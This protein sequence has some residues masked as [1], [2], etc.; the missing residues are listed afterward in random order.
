MCRNMHMYHEYVFQVHYIQ[1]YM[2]PHMQH[3]TFLLEPDG[4]VSLGGKVCMLLVCAYVDFSL[5]V[6]CG[7]NWNYLLMLLAAESQHSKGSD[8]DHWA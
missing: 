3:N 1:V 7:E 6:F 2:H 8:M 4:E 5:Y